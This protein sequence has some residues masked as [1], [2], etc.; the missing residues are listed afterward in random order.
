MFPTAPASIKEIATA[1]EQMIK[2]RNDYD[3]QEIRKQVVKRF[4]LEN[5][6]KY[7]IGVYKAVI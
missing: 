2:N 7:L 4:G 6:G 3:P 1:M 5:F